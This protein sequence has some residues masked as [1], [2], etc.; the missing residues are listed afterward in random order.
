MARSSTTYVPGHSH[1]VG[2]KRRKISEKVLTAFAK[3]DIKKLIEVLLKIAYSETE[4]TGIRVAAADKALARLILQPRPGEPTM[5]V[6][7]TAL[8]IGKFI[9][10]LQGK[11]PMENIEVLVHTLLEFE[12]EQE[13]LED[14]TE[15]KGEDD[16]FGCELPA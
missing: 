13:E 10:R 1:N 12:E 14:E 4:Q 11:I 2:L 3:K 9:S 15:E 8:L 16:E 5:N 6:N 7:S